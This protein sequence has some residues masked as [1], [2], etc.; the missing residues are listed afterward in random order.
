[1]SGMRA[2]LDCNASEVLR[3]VRRLAEAVQQ[4]AGELGIAAEILATR[5]DLEL[6]ARGQPVPALESGWR[7]ETIGE[8][9]RTLV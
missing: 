1:M 4:V 8:R 9:L 3:L 7:R 6:L 5:R 2:Y